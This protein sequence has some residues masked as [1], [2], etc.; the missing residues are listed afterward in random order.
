MC[1]RQEP[2][3]TRL[4][5]VAIGNIH[6]LANGPVRNSLTTCGRSGQEK[7]CVLLQILCVDLPPRED[8]DG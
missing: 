3:S 7:C 1:S 4:E 8:E 2:V 6:S 5:N